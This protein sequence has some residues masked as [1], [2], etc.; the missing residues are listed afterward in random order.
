MSALS[1][2]FCRQGLHSAAAAA[3][4]A[5]GFAAPLTP[6]VS[7]CHPRPACPPEALELLL[8]LTAAR[9]AALEAVGSGCLAYN[10]DANAKG[11]LKLSPVEA[12]PSLLTCCLL[13]AIAT[14]AAGGAWGTG[15]SSDDCRALGAL[16][17]LRRSGA[18]VGAGRGTISR[19]GRR[20][21]L[22]W[23]EEREVL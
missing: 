22:I 17:L 1:A 7:S 5:A 18:V 6:L 20:W 21:E 11:E 19:W 3:A 10:P 9:V 16:L 4:A 23:G 12:C 14:A 8:R 13:V 15:S 2:A